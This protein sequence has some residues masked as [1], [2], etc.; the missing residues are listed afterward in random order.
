[1]SSTTISNIAELERS[2][3]NETE[4][5]EGAGKAYQPPKEVVRFSLID[6]DQRWVM[7]V[8]IILFSVI[9]TT[10]L[11]SSFA[12]VFDM[13]AWVGHPGVLQWLP[14]LFLDMAILGYTWALVVFK[15]RSRNTGWARFGLIVSTALS[16]AANATHTIDFWHGDLTSYQ[17]VLGVIVSA[18]IPMLA[19]LATEVLIRL[20]FASPEDAG[21][22]AKPSTTK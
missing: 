1:M 6:P 5:V 15:R 9:L 12:S 3:E 13:S 17:A 7:I 2:L 16:V 21:A 19:L 18:I 22:Q 11:V 4:I 14:A 20:V 8:A 10:S